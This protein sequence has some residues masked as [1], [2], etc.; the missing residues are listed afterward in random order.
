MKIEHVALYVKDLESEKDFFVKYFGGKPNEGYHNAKTG[1]R[2]YFLTFDGGARLELM[3][4]PEMHDLEKPFNRTGWAHIA[5][6]LG[7]RERVDELTAQLRMD[8]YEIVSG[9]RV[10][11][12]GY[13]ESC[14]LDREGNQIELTE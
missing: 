12:D 10:T 4:K 14:F 11:G 7:F 9:P 1:F 8:G 2:S 3:Q 5:F 13:Y 6:S